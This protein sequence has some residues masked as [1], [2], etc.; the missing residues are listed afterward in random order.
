VKYGHDEKV[1][2]LSEYL[3]HLRRLYSLIYRWHR[4]QGLAEFARRYPQSAEN[5]EEWIQKYREVAANLLPPDTATEEYIVKIAHQVLAG[6]ME[7]SYCEQIGPDLTMASAAKQIMHVVRSAE[8]DKAGAD[9]EEAL[10]RLKNTGPESREPHIVEVT[11][12]DHQLGSDL[13]TVHAQ[14]ASRAYGDVAEEIAG[15]TLGGIV[16]LADCNFEKEMNSTAAPRGVLRFRN[17]AALHLEVD[18][19][20]QSIVELVKA[21]AVEINSVELGVSQ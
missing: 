2:Y 10:Q 21:G 12:S 3:E 11:I 1:P 6:C 14:L 8:D 20:Q 7:W 9:L 18:K 5:N 4:T 15:T 19:T 13:V 16:A 17:A